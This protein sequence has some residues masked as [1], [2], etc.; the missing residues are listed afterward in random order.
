MQYVVVHFLNGGG[1][2]RIVTPK[3]RIEHDNHTSVDLE[4]AIHTVTS[5]L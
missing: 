2:G 1:A 5:Y 4:K 3:T